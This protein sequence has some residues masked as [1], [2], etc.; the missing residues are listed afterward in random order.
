MTPLE[1]RAKLDA[2]APLGVS[3][4]NI[5]EI[6]GYASHATVYQWLTGKTKIPQDKADFINNLHSWWTAND[7]R[8]ESN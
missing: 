1:L 2:L 4:R 8:K 3:Q 7:P 5:A 6:F